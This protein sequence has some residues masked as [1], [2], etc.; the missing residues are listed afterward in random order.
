MVRVPCSRAACGGTIPDVKRWL[1]AIL[2]LVCAQRAH[3]DCP[4]TPD[5]AV[6]RPWTAVFLPTVIGM[7][8]VPHDA[9]GPWSG[10]GVE[11][12]SVWSDNTPAFGPSQG[13]LRFD[14]GALRSSEMGT[15]T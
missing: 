3:A 2:W 4:T 8:Y 7:V 1:A 5:D 9:A 14:I 6:C 10:G 11:I 13:K 12:T 15:G